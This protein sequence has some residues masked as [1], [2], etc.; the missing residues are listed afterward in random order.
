MTKKELLEKNGMTF[1][2]VC[3]FLKEDHDSKRRV[4]AT[5]G[6]WDRS[7]FRG[8]CQHKGVKYLFGKSHLNIKTLRGMMR[9]VTNTKSP[10]RACEQEAIPF[11]GTAHRGVDDAYNAAKILLKLLGEENE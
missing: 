1:A 5:W 8:D 9:G 4:W 6:D 7:K 2:E 3:E 10:S 11:E